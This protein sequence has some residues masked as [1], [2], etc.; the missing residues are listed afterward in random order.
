MKILTANQMKAVDEGTI[1]NEGI[2][3]IDLMERAAQACARRILKLKKNGQE[4]HVFC[5]MGNNGGD[6]LAIARLIAT[7]GVPCKAFVIRY[8]ETLSQDAEI[9]YY[10]L[11]EMF[12][13]IVLDIRDV[14]DLPAAGPAMAV[15]ALFGTGLSKPVEGLAADVIEKMNTGYN[16]VVS[17]D[18][19]SGLFADRPSEG[20]A[21]V[22]S[23]LTLTFQLPKLSLLLPGSSQYVPEFEL[24]DIGLNAEVIA[25]QATHLHYLTS[26]DIASVLKLRNK[27]SHKGMFGHALLLAGSTGKSG[28]AIIAARACL[29]SGA[30][31]LTVHSNDSTLGALNCHLP[32]AMSSKDWNAD[33]IT[34]VHHPEKYPAIGF[35]PGVGTDEETQPVLKK[36]LQYAGGRMVIDADGL[37]ILA[38]N[39]TWL[40]FLPQ[41]TILTPHPGEFERLAGKHDNDFERINALKQLSVR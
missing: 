39:K 26:R 40:E 38:E 29:R 31:L 3:S 24:V 37:N 36:L 27:F 28:A 35:G 16:Q 17:I 1:R 32:E 25:E 15:D 34:E 11:S 2:P 12:P 4:I 19:P 41:D 9:N 5:G 33:R 13:G 21:I 8:S 20:K 30:G 23:G 14:N 7:N 10:R 22:R 18:L 6:G